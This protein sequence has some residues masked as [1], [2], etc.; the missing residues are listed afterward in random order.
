MSFVLL[1]V[2]LASFGVG[3]FY[4]SYNG[5]NYIKPQPLPPKIIEDIQKGILLKHID[6]IE[7]E[8]LWSS[9]DHMLRQIN[10]RPRLKKTTIQD[11]IRKED[12][13]MKDLRE[14]LEKRRISTFID[15]D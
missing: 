14:K 12:P 8:I 1:A 4:G 3:Y 11:K 9:H 5:P 15:S 7:N 10:N 6:L 13:W 2:P